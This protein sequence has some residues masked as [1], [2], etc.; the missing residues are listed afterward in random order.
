MKP[1]FFA[2]PICDRGGKAL[3]ECYLSACEH[4]RLPF[5]WCDCPDKREEL[6]QLFDRQSGPATP[7]A[8][9][10]TGQGREGSE[11]LLGKSGGSENTARMKKLSVDPEV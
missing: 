3:S 1:N 6:I 10:L 2:G 4:C 11:W 9:L 7:P 5:S 8:A